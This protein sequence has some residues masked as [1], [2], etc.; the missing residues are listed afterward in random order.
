MI[1]ENRLARVGETL[2]FIVVMTF[3]CR[4]HRRGGLVLQPGWIRRSV[5]PACST[6]SSTRSPHS[7]MPDSR[8]C[9]TVL[10]ARW[11]MRNRVWQIMIMLLIVHRRFGHAG[12]RGSLV[13]VRGEVQTL[14]SQG[15]SAPAAAGSHAAGAGGHRDPHRVRRGG[16]LRHRVPA[17]KRTGKR[18]PRAHRV[19]PLRHRADRGIQHGAHVPDRSVS[20]RRC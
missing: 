17:R 16:D 9:R 8:R 6:R 11:C 4:G 2:Q 15:R 1:Q 14:A 10:P 5:R 20:P 3:I 13:L 12:G 18:R 19:F 7:A